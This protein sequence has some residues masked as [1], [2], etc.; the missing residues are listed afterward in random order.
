MT[1]RVVVIRGISGSG[2]STYAR[3]HYPGAPVCS[4]DDYFIGED[5][6]Y[7]FAPIKL[8]EAH[9]SC[10]RKFLDQIAAGT[11]TI[12]VDNTHT[13]VW[14]FSPYAA[15]ADAS[16]YQVTIVRMETPYKVAGERNVHGVPV[17]VVRGMEQRFEK[18]P[19]QWRETVVKGV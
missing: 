9:R 2:K 16:G 5:G 11:D 13:R 1:K 18:T 7:R 17:D 6:V 14:E 4:A 10:M 19:R 15:V 3:T 8:G 12:V